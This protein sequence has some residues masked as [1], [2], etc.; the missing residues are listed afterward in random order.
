VIGGVVSALVMSLLV[1]RVLYMV[2]NSPVDKRNE[3]RSI[4][5]Q[6]EKAEEKLEMETVSQ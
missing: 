6:T 4:N 3:H 5:H 1:L 2:F